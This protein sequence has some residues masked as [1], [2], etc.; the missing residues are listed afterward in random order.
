MTGSLIDS[1]DS[2]KTILNVAAKLFAKF[3]LD[4]CSTREIA[5]ESDCNISLISYYFG[6]KEGL[7][8]AVMRECAMEIKE[9]V[10][11]QDLVKK[12]RTAP[13][14][15]ALF[16]ED[17]TTTID[18][19]LFFHDKYP[20]VCQIFSREK[21]SGLQHSQEIHEEI[22]Y[23]LI[24]NFFKLIREAQAQKIVKKDINPALFFILLSEGVFGFFEMKDC[25]T[26]LLK[27]CDDLFN[28]KTKLSQQIA[29]IY[30]QGVLI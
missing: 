15:K 16:K 7:Y 1:I 24:Q 13:L 19:L 2:R 29:E 4:K 28:N 27:D 3:G 30:I 11:S 6:G 17:V 21:L 26:A 23:P 18:S 8:K 14:T 5:K 12:S 20:E 9:R 10:Q 25:P 22:F